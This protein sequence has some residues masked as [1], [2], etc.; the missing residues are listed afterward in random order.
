MGGQ[1]KLPEAVEEAIK[2]ID[3]T[4]QKKGAL[5]V[6]FESL[7]CAVWIMQLCIHV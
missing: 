4:A 3:V 6:G 1:E 5:W 2:K 7:E